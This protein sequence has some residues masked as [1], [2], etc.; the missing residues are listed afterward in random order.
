MVQKNPNRYEW[1]MPLELVYRS[2]DG[3]ITTLRPKIKLYGA[4]TND[5]N[6]VYYTLAKKE[7]I[8]LTSPVDDP[9]PSIH[10]FIIIIR[11]ITFSG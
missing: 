7:C 5:H 9:I 2:V 11:N 3:T 10:S 1:K 6:G 8:L 4:V